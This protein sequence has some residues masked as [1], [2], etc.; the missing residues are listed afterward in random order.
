MAGA[1]R[2]TAAW[3]PVQ[4]SGAPP[5]GAQL[6]IGFTRALAA[7]GVAVGVDRAGRFLAAARA[8]GAD[9]PRQVYWAGRITL[10]GSAGD[11][12]RFDAV[13]D[14]YFR[15]AGWQAP[16]AVRPA[17]TAVAAL[18]PPQGP[19]AAGAA[20][21][22]DEQAPSIPARAADAEVLRH[23]DLGAL[24]AAE[25]AELAVLFA[26][27]RPGL[28][29]RPSPRTRPAR[30]GRVDARRT[31]RAMLAAGGEAVVP[32]R[33]RRRARPR[34]VVLLLDVSGSMAPYADALLRFAHVLVR[35]RPA[36][37]EVFT[38]GTR[39][40]RITHALARPSAQDALTA[41]AAAIPDY[42]GGTRLGDGLRA[43]NDEWGQ[44]GVARGAVVVVCS[45]GWERGSHEPL[46]REVARL[47]RL[48]RALVW[49]NPHKG[50]S[51]YE[52]VQGG[53]VAVMPFLDHFL[54]GHS[55]ATL[56]ALLEVI[57]N[58]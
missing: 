45:D 20:V 41:A 35:R 17:S 54:A 47:S 4:T 7:A 15:G 22:P 38:V 42:A 37:V 29:T 2:A 55:L 33:R 36:A 46:T 25:R 24:T 18:L 3:P 50:K 49:V 43:F 57:R 40:S 6:L 52:P 16:R 39:L 58:A 1:G 5:D 11:R 34:R 48:A 9:D 26:L 10:T 27:L 31:V 28:P 53:I 51:G 12:A 19:E 44:R 14:A 32:A 21:P 13:F 56:E 8:L 30:R 23:R